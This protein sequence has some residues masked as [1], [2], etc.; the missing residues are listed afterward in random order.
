MAKKKSN[1]GRRRQTR[2]IDPVQIWLLC[3]LPCFLLLV[4]STGFSRISE[5]KTAVFYFLSGVLAVITRIHL[6]VE[7]VRA[8]KGGPKAVFSSLGWSPVRIAALCYLGFTLLS[9]ILSPYGGTAWYNAKDH[10]NMVSELC[11]LLI[12]Y[13]V[14]RWARPDQG[15]KYCFLI[16]AAVYCGVFALQLLHGNPLGLYPEGY[17]YFSLYKMRSAYHFAATTGN[18]DLVSVILCLI[19]PISLGIGLTE[20]GWKRT[21]GL[22]LA[23]LSLA[24]LLL[25]DVLCGVVGLFLGF[26]VSALVLARVKPRTRRVIFGAVV[27]LGVGFLGFLW[28]VPTPIPFFREIHSIL[29]GEIS[30]SFGSGRVEIWRKMLAKLTPRQILFGCGPDTVRLTGLE[31]FKTYGPDGAL[32]RSASITDAHCWPLQILYCQG[33]FALLSLIAAVALA[34]VPWF[35]AKGRS[36]AVEILG[37]ALLCFLFAMLFCFT[38]VIVM[39]LFWTL[40]GLLT[41]AGARR[42]PER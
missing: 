32:L 12:F 23:V 25:L 5:F 22:A 3:F 14:S 39:P 37:A 11:Y 26:V 9:T 38:S 19:V 15:L 36:P 42:E 7:A 18:A 1:P 21:P 28:Y 41:A 20:R 17:D 24:E 10:G 34:F 2:A 27:A 13:A 6:I 4:N 33:I 30:D 16:T 40:L 31:P 29:H 8:R 35:R